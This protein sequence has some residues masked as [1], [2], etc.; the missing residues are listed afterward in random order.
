M[1][2]DDLEFTSTALENAG[3]AVP[4]TAAART[5]KSV[6]PT[7]WNRG[8]DDAWAGQ[9]PQVGTNGDWHD[10]ERAYAAGWYAAAAEILTRRR[11]DCA[12]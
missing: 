2:T 6:Y 4:E 8:Y 12:V 9:P 10:A 1:E 7:S 5:A 3:V 11:V